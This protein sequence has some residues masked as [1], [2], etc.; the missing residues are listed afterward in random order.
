MI[1]S[2]DGMNQM[3]LAA[4]TRAAPPDPAGLPGAGPR[5]R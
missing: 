1:A 3:A 2:Q 4:V 5:N